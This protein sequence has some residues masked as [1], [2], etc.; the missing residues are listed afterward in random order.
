L[1]NNSE[2]QDW[3]KNSFLEISYTGTSPSGWLHSIQF[4]DELGNQLLAKDSM[5]VKIP[6]ASL[7]KLTAGKKQLKIYMSI[8]PTNPMI[9]APSR[10]LHLCTLKLP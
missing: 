4:I 8:S 10:L 2:Q 9:M 6:T 7:R 5:Y 1:E 3:K